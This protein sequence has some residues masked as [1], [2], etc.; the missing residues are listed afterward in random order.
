MG[1]NYAFRPMTAA[2]FPQLERWLALPHVAEWWGDPCRQ[3]VLICGDLNEPAI[4]QFVVSNAGAPI[5][6]LQCYELTEWDSG[7]GPQ[8]AGTLGIDLFIG[9]PEV[10]G[11]GYSS[12]LIRC[13]ADELLA[14]GTPRVLADP[15][16]TNTRAIRAYQKAGFEKKRLVDTPDGPA[17]LMFRE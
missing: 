1:R 11:R 9:S 14:S 6:Y 10:L 17:L 16:P 13:F 8:P 7:F 4:R 2:D 5:G 3:Y 15:N 12:A